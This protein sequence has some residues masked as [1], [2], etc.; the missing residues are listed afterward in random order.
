MFSLGIFPDKLKIAKVKPIFKSCNKTNPS[1]YRLISLL[2]IFS[3][4][5]EKLI[6]KRLDSF[7]CKHCI[8]AATQYGFRA[9]HSTMHA[10]TDVILA[11]YDN[12][13]DQKYTGL[14]FLDIKKAFDTVNHNILIEKLEHLGIRGLAKKLLNSYL[15][16]RNQFV[17]LEKHSQTYHI[18]W[19]VP[20]GSTLGPLLFLLY[21]N[22]IINCTKVTPRLFADDTCLVFNAST[23][24]SLTDKINLDLANICSWMKSNKLCINA[25]KSIALIILPKCYNDFSPQNLTIVY[26]NSTIT[27]SKS[28]KYLGFKLITILS[29]SLIYSLYIQS[30][31]DLLEFCLKSNISCPAVA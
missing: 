29:L 26:D 8:I 20:Q 5:F 13:N 19:G 17:A 2:T 28:A 31:H 23:I 12:I 24:N 10:V 11:V 21:I 30:F 6:Y 15:S 1:N 18:K 27:I 16:G 4:I 9:G 14:I 3:K 25:Q 22:D 7:I